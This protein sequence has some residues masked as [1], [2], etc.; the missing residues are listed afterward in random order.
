MGKLKDRVDSAS[1][2][3]AK[4]V[5]VRPGP[6]LRILAG[7]PRKDQAPHLVV[8]SRQQLA[9]TVLE[10]RFLLVSITDPPPVPK[11]DL[12]TRG[13]DKLLDCLELPF[14]DLDPADLQESWGQPV[15]A[16]DRTADQLIM[17]RELGKKLWSFL[18]RR[19][20]PVAEVFVLQDDGDRRALSLAY[21][22]ADVLGWTRSRAIYKVGG[23]E[24]Q[25]TDAD[26]PPNRFVYDMAKQTRAMVM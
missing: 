22:I 17:T 7:R 19:R 24:W 14:A 20:D 26:V 18:L 15:P 8:C 12:P 5:N 10:R 21:A 23:H 11:A 2:A 16:Y 13:S 6:L 3:F 9:S 25:A 4:L 1:G